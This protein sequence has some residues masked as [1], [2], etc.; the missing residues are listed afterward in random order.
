L[1]RFRVSILERQKCVLYIFYLLMSLSAVS[2]YLDYCLEKATMRSL[3]IV[4]PHV[5]VG[6]IKL[7]ECYHGKAKIGSHFIVVVLPNISYCCQQYNIFLRLSKKSR[8]FC[9]TLTGFVFSQ[10]IFIK[11]PISNFTKIL[12]VGAELIHADRR[13]DRHT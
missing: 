3:W 7:F 2:K 5:A 13:T 1:W 6:N 4:E 8:N 10:Q 11:V 9:P 12:P